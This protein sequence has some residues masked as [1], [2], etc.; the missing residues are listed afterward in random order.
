MKTAV[1]YNLDCLV[2]FF[3]SCFFSPSF[4]F[5]SSFFSF[6]PLQFSFLPL[7]FSF[8]LFFSLGQ[9]GRYLSF[10]LKNLIIPIFSI[11]NLKIV[12]YNRGES[13]YDCHDSREV[14]TCLNI[15]NIY[16]MGNIYILDV[17][18]AFSWSTHVL[19]IVVTFSFTF[20]HNYDRP[21]ESPLPLSSTV[22]DCTFFIP[23]DN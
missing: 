2:Y 23:T 18:L 22:F 14:K 15:W 12:I 7:F 21:S 10:V 13:G 3:S 8:R 19:K 17:N 16:I 4:F 6:L 9:V 20:F 11:G 5:S 1:D